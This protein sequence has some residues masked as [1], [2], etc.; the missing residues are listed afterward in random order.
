MGEPSPT[1][2]G[3]QAGVVGDDGVADRVME[4]D[5][6]RRDLRERRKWSGV[7]LKKTFEAMQT[8]ICC[9]T[10]DSGLITLMSG[11]SAPR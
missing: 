8:L 2:N 5:V 9:Q 4:R 1:S 11:W 6:R 3:D 7:Q 10:S